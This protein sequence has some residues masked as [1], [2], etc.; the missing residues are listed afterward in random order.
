MATLLSLDVAGA[1]DAVSH[2][3]LLHNL[4]KR[5][6]PEYLVRWVED[7]LKDRTT[8]IRLGDFTLKR[9]TIHAG[10]P[11]GSPI[12]PILYL[13]YNTDLLE[14]CQNIGLKTSPIGFVDDVNILTFGDTTERNCRNLE[15]IHSACE[16]WAKRHGSQFNPGKYELIHFTRTPRRFDIEHGVQIQ[17]RVIRPAEAIRV[18]GVHID[19]KL[20]WKHHLR[21]V[22]SQATRIL[23]AF[24]SISGSTWGASLQACRQLYMA[25][26]RPAITYGA[27]AWHTPDGCQGAQKG[28]VKKL[29]AIQARFLRVT[30]GAYRA[31]SAE[32]LEIETHIPPI[33]MFLDLKVARSTLRTC[34][35]QA[36]REAE[37]ATQEIRRQMRSKRGR[38]ARVRQTPGDRRR[39]WVK[40]WAGTLEPPVEERWRPPWGEGEG[41]VTT[42]NAGETP[43]EHGARAIN[44]LRERMKERWKQEWKGG[45]KG[46][47]LKNLEPEPSPA[48][49]KRHAGRT[50][51]QSALLVQLRTGKV[52]FQEFLY[53]R[54][55]PNVLSARCACGTGAMTV[56]H[57]LLSCPEWRREREEE[58]GGRQRD[59][60][61]ILRGG[62]GATAALRLVLRIGILD[63]FRLVAAREIPTL[64]QD[65]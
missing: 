14:V 1:F 12:S 44:A 29:R 50:K 18:L 17:G 62:V 4:R 35:S 43:A 52:G 55:V 58:L 59:L 2:A 28:V 33:G 46:Q 9:S 3:R 11:Q 39:E 19:A 16:E 15:R 5:K 48:W 10:I 40:Q 36:Y 23:G 60:R 31:T 61:E 56:R 64:P 53:Q 8:E 30:C 26:A 7:F 22:E 41:E 45:T 49:R 37:K 27:H 32:A 47:H 63:Q 6:I 25:V 20:R 51:A 57:V 65:I 34:A 54:K 21:A 42:G 24:Q 38:Q 13:F